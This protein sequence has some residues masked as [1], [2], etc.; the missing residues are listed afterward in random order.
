MAD[1][2]LDLFEHPV[3]PELH[4][5]GEWV[6]AILGLTD[7]DIDRNAVRRRALVFRSVEETRAVLALPGRLLSSVSL[8]VVRHRAAVGLAVLL[9]VDQRA[10][11]DQVGDRVEVDGVGLATQPQRLQRDRSPPANGSSTF[12]DVALGIRMQ[13]LVGGGDQLAGRIDVVRDVRVLPPDQMLDELQAA[14]AGRVLDRRAVAVLR[15]ELV[16]PRSSLTSVRKLSGHQGRRGRGS[17]RRTPPP[18]TPP[19]V[20]VPTRCAASRCAHAGSTSPEPTARR[21]PSA[22]GRLRSG[23]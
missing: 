12:G 14:V 10:K 16:R 19:G 22:A 1:G 3:P 17:A 18:G 13:E 11:L 6:V 15:L 5:S 4:V 8:D 20:A 2:W 21:L 7:L 23:V 9:R